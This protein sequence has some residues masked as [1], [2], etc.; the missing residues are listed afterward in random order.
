VT[1]DGVAATNFTVHSDM[2]VTAKVPTGAKTGKIDI[3]TPGGTAQS[4][5]HFTVTQ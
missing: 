5:T 2:L 4:A 1:F 3:T